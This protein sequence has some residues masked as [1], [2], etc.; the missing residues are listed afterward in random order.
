MIYLWEDKYLTSPYESSICPYRLIANAY[1]TNKVYKPSRPVCFSISISCNDIIEDE[2][3]NINTLLKHKNLD[4]HVTLD[5]LE[6]YGDSFRYDILLCSVLSVFSSSINPSKRSP[7]FD[8][9]FEHSCTLFNDLRSNK[10]LSYI[11]IRQDI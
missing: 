5:F 1:L 8:L 4:F 10:F 9:I 7:L 2:F 6:S 3:L 11:K